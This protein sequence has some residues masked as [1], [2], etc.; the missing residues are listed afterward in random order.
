[1]YGGVGPSNV[2]EDYVRR[3]LHE[4]SY[5]PAT[6]MRL[7]VAAHLDFPTHQRLP[8]ARAQVRAAWINVCAEKLVGAPAATKTVVGNLVKSRVA[9]RFVHDPEHLGPP[10]RP[11]RGLRTFARHP[12]RRAG[13]A[14]GLKRR[15]YPGAVDH[16]TAVDGG[17]G[18]ALVV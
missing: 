2:C 4:L 15:L 14:V 6:V 8:A 13:A 3:P 16:R 10:R 17:V 18:Y 9:W 5:L 11:C 1:M 12:D 7:D